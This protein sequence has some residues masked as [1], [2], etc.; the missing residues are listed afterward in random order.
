MTQ[1]RTRQLLKIGF[2]AA[3][4]V[5]AVYLVKGAFDPFRTN[6]GDS[7]SDGN[8]MTSGRYF[9]RDG[10]IKT[11]FTPILDIGPLDHNSLRYTHYPP[12][13]DL[14]S[15]VV[16]SIIGTGYIAIHRLL[17][18]VFTGLGLWFFY[19]YLERIFARAVAMLSVALLASNFLFIQYA[20][21]VHHIPLYMMTG[22]G[23]MAAAIR[24]VDDG[25]RR[26]LVAVAVATYFCFLAS[27]DFYF[28]ASIMVPATVWL[29]RHSVWRGRGLGL[30]LAYGLSG[31]ASIATKNLLVI[32]AVGY[33]QWHQDFVF[34]FLE[35]TTTDR[36]PPYQAIF[37]S[38]V[39]WRLW[40][41]GTPLLFAAMLGQLVAVVDRVRG[42]TTELS[43]KPLILLAAGIP[44]LLVFSQLTV[45]QFHPTLLLLPYAAV[46]TALLLELAWRRAPVVAVALALLYAGWQW[47]SIAVYTK[48]FL[49]WRDVDAVRKVLPF[50]RHRIILTN[51]FIDSPVR[52]LWDRYFWGLEG[53]KDSLVQGMRE[54]FELFGNETPF[55]IV[56][57]KKFGLHLYDKAPF[58][59]FMS[60]RRDP[61]ITHPDRYRDEILQRFNDYSNNWNNAL[62]GVGDVVWDSSEMRVR[63]FSEAQLDRMQLDHL[64]VETPSVIDFETADSE[65]FKVR[66][67]RQRS[68]GWRGWHGYTEIYE[69]HRMGQVF[70]LHGFDFPQIGPSR[71][72]GELQMRLPRQP[73]RMV[74]EMSTPTEHMGFTIAINHHVMLTS[75]LE[76]KKGRLPV[77]IDATPDVLVDGVQRIQ[78]VAAEPGVNGAP[79]RFHRLE[80]V[81]GCDSSLP[82]AACALPP[83]V[84]P[85]ADPATVH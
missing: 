16:Q 44:F 41:F 51:I 43:L 1:A 23:L 14:V 53:D 9:M 39:V 3:L 48:T 4:L 75:V 70:T 77:V 40:R 85:A 58:F 18:I 27:Y 62:E 13:P 81:R 54:R 71:V 79:L 42:R 22:F 10:F 30:L 35:R 84:A 68:G 56:Q 29:R 34:Q 32:W 8:A 66:G 33:E 5:V 46:S 2:A 82:P 60:E 20:D 64:P 74:F 57:M 61:W 55:T 83:G 7:V 78:I 49:R 65:A 47:R 67:F 50:D 19:L 26:H 63:T 69:R 31:I 25:R 17:A 38:T 12:L 36:S 28:F 76:S 37:A 15:G 73:V 72:D 52:Y 6:W 45:E 24:W 80:F 11:A 21:T 59:W